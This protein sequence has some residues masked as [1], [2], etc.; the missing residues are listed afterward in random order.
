MA[1]QLAQGGRPHFHIG[2]RAHYF[3]FMRCVRQQY[4]GR[5]PFWRLV[6]A[7]CGLK[8]HSQRFCSSELCTYCT[9]AGH[10]ANECTLRLRANDLLF[11]YGYVTQRIAPM[12]RMALILDVPEGFIPVPPGGPNRRDYRSVVTR[13]IYPD[14]VAN[15]VK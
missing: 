15:Q 7:A 10:T 1:G 11:E 9:Y 6:C 8:G 2:E 5:I 12:D 4:D 13:R 14:D 3:E